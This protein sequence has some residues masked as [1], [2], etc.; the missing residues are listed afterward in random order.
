MSDQNIELH[1]FCCYENEKRKQLWFYLF[2]SYFNKFRCLVIF[3]EIGNMY[4]YG[5][6][7]IFFVPLSSS[8]PIS[9]LFFKVISVVRCFVL[10]SLYLTAS[11]YLLARLDLIRQLGRQ[12]T[13]KELSTELSF[14]G[15]QVMMSSQKFSQ[16]KCYPHFIL[17][18][19]L[20]SQ[21]RL[22]VHILVNLHPSV[23][24]LAFF[25]AVRDK[26]GNN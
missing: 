4:I 16:H 14:M 22:H 23:S 1:I 25:T 2:N 3:A 17:L 9:F 5:G 15:K 7:N 8:F 20:A 12:N 13:E 19:T 21:R 6:R 10:Q 26:D 24:R 11:S 18:Y